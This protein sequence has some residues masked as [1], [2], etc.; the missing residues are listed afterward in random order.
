M[1]GFFLGAL[2]LIGLDV[3]LHAP[4]SRFA[5]MLATPTRWLAEWTNAGT[6]LISAPIPAPSSSSGGTDNPPGAGGTTPKGSPGS[7]MKQGETYWRNHGQPNNC[8]PGFPP[9]ITCV[10]D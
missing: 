9:N 8:P 6:P 10:A 1:R 7:Q 4:T 3:A 2:L 5:S